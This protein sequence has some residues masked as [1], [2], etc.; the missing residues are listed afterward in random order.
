MS[1]IDKS[2]QRYKILDT[3]L[4]DESNNWTLEDL[5]AQCAE[6]DP[7]KQV[8]LRT[9]QMDLQYLRS[10]YQ[11]PIQVFAGKFYKYASS[12]FSIFKQMPAG[13]ELAKL[14]NALQVLDSLTSFSGLSTLNY[15]LKKLANTIQHN[16]LGTDQ[17][18]SEDL[19]KS[20]V[21]LGQILAHLQEQRTLQLSFDKR[22]QRVNIN[23]CPYFMKEQEGHLFVCG[24]NLER[25]R[26]QIIA[27]ESI[28]ECGVST[29]AFYQD[30]TFNAS[31]FRDTI[32]A[33]RRSGDLPIVL[34][35]LIDPDFAEELM[36]YPVHHS[37]QTIS[38]QTTGTKVA[39]KVIWNDALEARILSYGPKLQVLAPKEFRKRIFSMV[40]KAKKVYEGE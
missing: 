35:L 11:A 36:Q 18:F 40:K 32:G 27:L 21:Y 38:V 28:L 26:I 6:N 22:E 13:R 29:A 4:A 17:M 5:V 30:P 33:Q 37:Q 9:V 23:F 14:Q 10:I 3:C 39:L 34:H 24:W 19:D 31:Y 7:E 12:D 1:N 2:F 25:A 15:E 16:L 20:S 8:G